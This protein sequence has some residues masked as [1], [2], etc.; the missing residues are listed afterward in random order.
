M[1]AGKSK[2]TILVLSQVYVPDPAAVGQQMADAAE[3]LARRGY[4]V[5]VLTSARGYDDPTVRYPARE[6]RGGVAI[7]RLPFS[8]F[9]KKTILHRLM[10]QSIFLLQTL[11]RGCFTRHLSGILVSTSPPMCSI[12]AWII[13]F[14]RGVKMTYWIMDINPDQMIALGH[15]TEKS[16]PSR[17][18]NGLN[19]R[20]LSR[21]DDVIVLD[22]FMADRINRKAGVSHKMTILPPWPL[23]DY[24][25]VVAHDENPFR[26]EHG[27]IGKFVIM[28]SGNHGHSNPVTTVL[29]A[30]LR[31]QD[32][33]DLVFAFVGGGMGKQEVEQTIAEH[34]PGNI[35]SLPYQPLESLRYSLSAADVHV[36]TVGESVVG[37]VHPCKIYGAMSVARPILL[38]APDPCHVS[39]LVEPSGIGWHIQHGD[40]DTAVETIRRI[41]NTDRETLATMGQ[42]ARHII[43]QR[44]SK[45]SLLGQFSDVVERG[46]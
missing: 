27:L 42:K 25:G 19:R 43:K 13:S 30:A 22:R 28:Y 38:V 6:T 23:D 36:V 1:A 7:V 26:K 37:V 45:T 41:R 33:E 34:R 8:S 16:L 2:R 46:L 39:D 9:G 20:I 32:D 44:F 17:I 21:A 15:L 10:G 5:R 29:Q 4:T 31:L 11:L 24:L 40:L 18:F 3:E 12:A 35:I 14:L